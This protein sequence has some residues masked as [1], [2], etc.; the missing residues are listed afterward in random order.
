MLKRDSGFLLGL[1]DGLER[2]ISHAIAAPVRT[3][4]S[5]L[6][7]LTG[8]PMSTRTTFQGEAQTRTRPA[9]T[10]AETQLQ[11]EQSHSFVS[12]LSSR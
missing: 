10:N 4:C 12:H 9:L 11:L 8:S 5:Q 3:P 1:G 6:G 7:P 2:R